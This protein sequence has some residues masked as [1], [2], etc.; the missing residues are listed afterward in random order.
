M[1]NVFSPQCWMPTAPSC[2]NSLPLRMPWSANFQH[3]ST[4]GPSAVSLWS[5][6][7]NISLW[8]STLDVCQWFSNAKLSVHELKNR[9]CPYVTLQYEKQTQLFLIHTS[10]KR[11]AGVWGRAHGWRRSWVRIWLL[12][13]PT[14]VTTANSCASLP[15][16]SSCWAV[17]WCEVITY[18]ALLAKQWFQHS[19]I[20]FHA[21]STRL[22]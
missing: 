16:T 13:P 20:H 19:L 15:Q 2:F 11:R 8:G 3:T 6:T 10:P 18:G 22:A 12:C 5:S 17:P 9:Y 21:K 14:A 1:N 7:V 4:S